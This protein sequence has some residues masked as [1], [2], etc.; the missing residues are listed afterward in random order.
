V[1]DE[2]GRLAK[3]IDELAGTAPD[4]LTA[5]VKKLQ[6]TF[7]SFNDDVQAAKT[8]LDLAKAIKGQADVA[9]DTSVQKASD[10]VEAWT[11]DNCDS[12]GNTKN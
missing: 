9:K 1:H 4:E 8:P 10:R 7:D 12:E 3:Q 6:T 2:F 5:S 11:Q